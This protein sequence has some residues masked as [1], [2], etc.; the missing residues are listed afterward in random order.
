MSINI[1][2]ERKLL[3]VSTFS[4]LLFALMGIGLGL[5]MGSLVIVFDGAYSLVSLA[6]TLVSL[7]AAAYMHSAVGKRNKEISGK[8]EPM[9]IAFKGMVI[10]LMC[11]LSLVSAVNAILSGGREV[12]GGMAL[13]FGVVN[14]AGCLATFTLMHK[15]SQRTRSLL[16]E[17]EAKQWMMDTVISAAVMLGF[18][19]SSVMTYAGYSEYAVYADPAMVVIASLYF[20]I[21]PIKMVRNAIGQLRDQQAMAV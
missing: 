20:G 1:A 9:V 5:W 13:L 4:A 18:I 17:A 11:G 21:V 8:L 14:V 15:F 12:D 16:V 7:G 6:L 2:L 3:S 10:T 19:T